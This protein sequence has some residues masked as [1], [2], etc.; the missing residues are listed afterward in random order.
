LIDFIAGAFGSIASWIKNGADTVKN[1]FLSLWHT[2][3]NLGTNVWN[4]WTLA[5]HGVVAIVDGLTKLAL[6]AFRSVWWLFTKYI[7]Q[8]VTHIFDKVGLLLSRLWDDLRSWVG[9]FVA[10]VKAG[11]VRIINDVKQWAI[12]IFDWVRATLADA[13]NM[14]QHVANIVDQYLGNLDHLVTA[15]IGKIVKALFQYFQ[16]HAE[17]FAQWAVRH[18]A[19]AALGV[20]DWL[21]G[22]IADVL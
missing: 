14:L 5:Y 11:I 6:E 17:S 3:E 10:D 18:I 12:D 2:I 8:T 9:T 19:V 22:I 1:V 4:A 15:I 20:A 21:E 16:D 7:P 13:W